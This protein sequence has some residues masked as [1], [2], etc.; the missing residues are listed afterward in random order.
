V[1]VDIFVFC[2]TL[3]HTG[4]DF[5]GVSFRCLSEVVSPSMGTLKLFLLDSWQKIEQL[6]KSEDIN[7]SIK[8]FDFAYL[9]TEV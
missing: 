5:N 8:L 4:K 7:F 9:F 6:L 3:K 2:V 1:G